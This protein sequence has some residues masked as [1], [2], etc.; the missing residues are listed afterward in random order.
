[1][2]HL[3]LAAPDQGAI[4]ALS[5]SGKELV[6]F[7]TF[8]QPVSIKYGPHMVDLVGYFGI[9]PQDINHN[10]YDGGEKTYHPLKSCLCNQEQLLKFQNESDNC[11]SS[12]L[13]ELGKIFCLEQP[14]TIMVKS[15][16]HDIYRL[17][18]D[19]KKGINLFKFDTRTLF[20]DCREAGFQQLQVFEANQYRLRMERLI[21]LFETDQ[22]PIGADTFADLFKNLT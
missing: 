7:H 17:R 10:Y 15:D 9:E 4:Y 12:S 21:G 13:T 19:P 8:A 2:S 3:F 14:A 11:F 5:H 22:T 20:D 6:T 16:Q 1:M 18:F